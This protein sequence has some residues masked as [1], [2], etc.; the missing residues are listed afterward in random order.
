MKRCYEQLL[1]GHV[2][3]DRQMAF[4]SGPRQVG[5]TTTA[6]DFVE[7]PH[8]FSWD[9]DD[10]RRLLLAGPQ[11]V[12]DSIG[13][14]DSNIIVFD[15]LH[16]WTGWKNFL[17][18]FF[19]THSRRGFKVVVTGSARLD[20]YRRGADSLMGRYFLYRMHPL[21][22]GE[23]V[24]P[25]GPGDLLTGPRPIGD[26]D[27]A[28]L[29]RFGGFPEPYL[30]RNPRF[31]NRWKG[32]RLKLLLREDLRDSTRILE[33][34]QVELLA[35]FLRQRAG[36]NAGFASLAKMI[37][38]SEDSIRRWIAV[39][40]SL[41][42]CFLIRPWSHNVPRSLLKEPK[43]YLWDWSVID[44]PGS[45]DE[46]LVASH[47]LKAVNWWQDTG[48]GDFGL[49]YLRTKDKRE[50]DFVVVRNNKPWFLVEAKSSGARPLSRNLSWFQER[51]GA[52]HAFQVVVDGDF[53][54]VDAF[55]ETRPVKVPARALLSQLI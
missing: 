35:E 44:N 23:I 36:Q 46:N 3:E 24:H 9:N 37:R 13:L 25:R 17:K 26:E 28:A 4:V 45:R 8:Y 32:N 16:K 6:T 49:F 55:S 18:G 50:V 12:M 27:F 52:E 51:T 42:F 1:V 53:V 21:T 39:L 14:S 29:Q 10:H 7:N 5:K 31:Y 38:A 15:E 41:Y 20:A 47:L 43:V 33:V 54:N 22:V 2:S 48:H 19:D 34:G 11:T 40:E 30:R